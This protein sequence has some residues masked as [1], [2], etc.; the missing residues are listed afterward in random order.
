MAD[1]NG[2]EESKELF[3][4]VGVSMGLFGIWTQVK[5]HF[6]KNF[7][8]Y[9]CITTQ[10][11]ESSNIS[12]KEHKTYKL[13]DSLEKNEYFRANWF[14][15]KY[16]NRVQEWCGVAEEPGKHEIIP[17]QDALANK[18]LAHTASFV[19]DIMRCLLAD[20][21]ASFLDSAAIALILSLFVREG[22][23]P[24]CD[25]WYKTLPMDNQ[26]EY[27]VFPVD[28]TEIWLPIDKCDEV[29]RKLE[30]LFQD[31]LAQGNF[32]TEI[33]GAKKSG[34]WLSMSYGG[35]YVR[36]DP[37]WS[38]MDWYD[39]NESS[40]REFF[41]KF[42]EALMPLSPDGCRLHWGKYMPKPGQDIAG[43]KYN[44]AYLKKVYPRMERWLE[45]RKMHDPN[46]IFPNKY[47]REYF[48]IA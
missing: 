18:F 40:M 21:D 14:P 1:R 12:M 15:Q 6:P 7:N 36:V 35:N 24:F 28:F 3:F 2:D 39:K 13:K 34:F 25:V 5:F 43:T 4:A 27:D 41:T 46:N 22:K 17:Y 45:L 47:W 37:Y 9:G 8:V 29:M 10:A 23:V 31:P 32:A 42:W 11:F 44:L 33:Y 38:R 30:D 16:F 19:L 48:E 20:G 26:I